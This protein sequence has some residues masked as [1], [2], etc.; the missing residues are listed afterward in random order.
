[1]KIQCWCHGG[2]LQENRLIAFFVLTVLLLAGAPGSA[3][4][5]K[6]EA[7]RGLI[8]TGVVS[9]LQAMVEDRAP[10][11]SKQQLKEQ[12]ET[13]S[14]ANARR[15]PGSV[16]YI[17]SGIVSSAFKNL[18]GAIQETKGIDKDEAKKKEFLK[19]VTELD[20]FVSALEKLS[21][22]P[23]EFDR[24]RENIMVASVRDRMSFTKLQIRSL[25]TADKWEDVI[26]ELASAKDLQSLYSEVLQLRQS[27]KKLAT[28]VQRLSTELEKVKVD[29]QGLRPSPTPDCLPWTQ[30]AGAQWS[31]EIGD[32]RCGLFRRLG[33]R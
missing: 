3:S 26:E 18:V 15:D 24:L 28:D 12:F 20:R 33:R 1:V 23:F 14:A 11:S 13:L 8:D 16:F 32:N 19:E 9:R 29:V 25:L 2:K 10:P 22:G 7:N 5:Q 27:V 30:P 6:A 31:Y 17:G 4:G 21:V